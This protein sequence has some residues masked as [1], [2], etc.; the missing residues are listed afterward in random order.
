MPPAPT[1]PAPTPPPT[2]RVTPR[3]WPLVC[4]SLSALLL[5]SC[6]DRVQPDATSTGSLTLPVVTDTLAPDL[7]VGREDGRPE[8]AFGQIAD[9]EVAADGS[10]HVVDRQAAAIRV[11]DS[12]G[13][14]VRS[15]GRAG[16]GPGEF[17]QAGQLAVSTDGTLWLYDYALRSLIALDSLG[18]EIDRFDAKE[19]WAQGPLSS[20][21]NGE[22]GDDGTLVQTVQHAE[23][24][25]GVALA[26]ATN[27]TFVRRFDPTTGEADSTLIARDPIRRYRYEG[28]G[29]GGGR[30]TFVGVVSFDPRRLVAV[31][32]SGE[33]W[34]ART[35]EYVLTR[36]SPE[37]DTIVVRVDGVDSTPTERTLEQWER[38]TENVDGVEPPTRNHI[39]WRLFVDSDGSV[40]VQ[41][42]EGSS[43]Q[44][45][46]DIFEADGSFRGSVIVPATFQMNV[47]DGHVYAVAF[48]EL[49]IGRVVR[50][51]V[52]GF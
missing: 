17:R 7:V 42:A 28:E 34:S 21:W 10:I 12:E 43:R 51:P 22:I 3:R 4:L 2:G 23:F 49:R 46:L 44:G 14:F 20:I 30:G 38:L 33:V 45:R 37:G 26:E 19:S 31:G 13:R 35:T 25:R 11:F 47:R 39:L 5:A 6:T 8:E 24:P 40:W 27:S 1:P 50:I 9:I 48:D 29:P 52:V 18:T 32:P 15:V 16:D 36:V 41:R